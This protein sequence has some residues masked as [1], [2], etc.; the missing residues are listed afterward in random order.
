MTRAFD[1]NKEIVD[2]KTVKNGKSCDCQC[3]VC[4][5]PLIAKQGKKNSWHFAH[6]FSSGEVDCQWSG[7]TELHLR[8]K[9]YISKVPSI[10]IP[11]GINNPKIETLQI[12]N[13]L[14]EMR[15]DP[16]RRIPDVTILSNGEKILVEIAVTHFCDQKKINE[17]KLTNV[18]AI[19]FDFSEFFTESDVIADRDIERHFKGIELISKWLS[20]APT[21]DL[22]QRI[23]NH[24]R[25]NLHSLNR[26]IREQKQEF[27]KDKAEHENKIKVLEKA[28]YSKQDQLNN[29]Q[30]II[31]TKT[32]ESEKMLAA[33]DNFNRNINEMELKMSLFSK[34]LL[35]Q[36]KRDAELEF[37]TNIA[38]FKRDLERKYINENN[39]LLQD[40]LNKIKL[41][42]ES[43]D[44]SLV[45]LTEAEGALSNKL[46]ELDD[47]KQET[48]KYLQIKEDI[49]NSL[50]TL[51]AKT[52][53]IAQIRKQLSRI[54]P[55]FKL[56][57]RNT[58][59]PCPFI[60]DVNKDLDV[61]VFQLLYESLRDKIEA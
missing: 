40:I 35:N 11:I 31:D 26:T 4:Y 19:E 1:V 2:V 37:N 39:V 42:E 44:L 20:I 22:G 57:Y 16:T 54:L 53:Q 3:I 10:S 50:S 12:D 45:K 38:N 18:N 51:A 36:A 5:S 15:Y 33:E 27:I 9:E 59:T 41:N 48:D 21:G 47:I 14:F 60:L 23:N 25:N 7:E 28:I 49:E 29:I 6:D 24:E 46:L 58:G 8:V 32:P 55:E 43:R 52:R 13:V 34:K 30:L 17:Y 61:D 56:Y